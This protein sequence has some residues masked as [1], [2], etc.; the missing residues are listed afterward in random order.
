MHLDSPLSAPCSPVSADRAMRI[1][2]T[3]FPGERSFRH[4]GHAHHVAAVAF[5][6]VDL[7]DRFQARALSCPVGAVR[8]HIDAGG[9]SGGNQY[10]AQLI[11]IGLV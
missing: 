2:Q 10:V 11:T 7:R 9:D 6:P 3:E 5:H 8:N 4:T 1:A